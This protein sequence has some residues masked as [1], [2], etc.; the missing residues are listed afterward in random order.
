MLPNNFNINYCFGT[1]KPKLFNMFRAEC[2]L[3]SFR[4]EIRLELVLYCNSCGAI[5]S[6]AVL[7]YTRAQ[8]LLKFMV[9]CKA[10]IHH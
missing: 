10:L 4:R 6:L 9:C 2:Q 1:I 7:G 5:P 3:C 8:E